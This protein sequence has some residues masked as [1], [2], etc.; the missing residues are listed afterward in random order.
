M[1]KEQVYD[2]KVAPLM[3]Q[4]IEICKEKQEMSDELL[5]GTN[6]PIKNPNSKG[7]GLDKDTMGKILGIKTLLFGFKKFLFFGGKFFPTLDVF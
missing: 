3:T 5:E 7:P 6:N 2:E 4:I 1:N